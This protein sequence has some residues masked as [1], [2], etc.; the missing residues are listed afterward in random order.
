[1]TGSSSSDYHQ[2][3]ERAVQ[4]ARHLSGL[5]GAEVRRAQ[6][7][8]PATPA[9]VERIQRSGSHLPAALRRFFTEGSGAVDFRYVFEPPSDGRDGD[10]LR[11]LFPDQTWIYGGVR[12]VAAELTDL[13]RSATE[14]LRDTWVAEDETQRAIWEGT[15]PFAALDNGDFLGL[16][17]RMPAHDPPLIYLSHED[18]SIVLAPSF[19]TFL[20]EW[21]RLCYLGP[22]IWLLEGFR[23]EGGFLEGESANAQELRVLL[24]GDS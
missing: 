9:E 21:A 2:W 10:R 16:D 8:P 7:G 23:D 13:Q 20:A 18:E 3:L 24:T 1:V 4:F 17:V 6:F 12:V 22:E 14:W 11:R 19:S 15:L 5:S